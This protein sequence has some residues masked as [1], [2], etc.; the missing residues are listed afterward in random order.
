ML[1]TKVRL[2][3]Y[4][5]K[6]RGYTKRGSRKAV[7]WKAKFGDYIITV[8]PLRL[9]EKGAEGWEYEIT[10]I[11]KG[12]EEYDSVFFHEPAFKTAEEAKKSAE[13]KIDEG[14]KK[15]NKKEWKKLKEKLEKELK[16][17]WEHAL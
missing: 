5:D 6:E 8:Y 9:Y 17:G 1:Y 4:K 14:I 13:E 11:K 15:K 10:N 3:W 12:L 2:K 7:V 16:E